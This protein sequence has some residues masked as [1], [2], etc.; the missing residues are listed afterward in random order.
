M[1]DKKQPFANAPKKKGKNGRLYDG[2]AEVLVANL[3]KEL[4]KIPST[5]TQRRSGK[6]RMR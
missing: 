3:G 1:S 4:K 5:K 6:P 2:D